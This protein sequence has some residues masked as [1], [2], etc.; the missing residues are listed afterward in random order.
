MLHE[1][2]RQLLAYGCY[3]PIKLGDRRFQLHWLAVENAHQGHGLGHLL[4]AAITNKI[5][6][7]G[8][9]KIYAE[10]SNRDYHAPVRVF[11]ESCGYRLAAA[12]A[13]YYADGDDKVIY[14]KD[15]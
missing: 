10:I 14:V 4:E 6:V 5:R 12:I 7:Q 9:L 11:Y 15:L 1:K 2:D 3:G 13:D 8:G